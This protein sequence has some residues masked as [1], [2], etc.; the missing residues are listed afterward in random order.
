MHVKKIQQLLNERKC[1]IIIT[2]LEYII[3]GKYHAN[4]SKQNFLNQKKKTKTK[5]QLNF[6]LAR[7]GKIRLSF[8]D[9]I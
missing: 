5:K 6:N 2:F 4:T 1:I 8:F 3:H 9:K 7:V